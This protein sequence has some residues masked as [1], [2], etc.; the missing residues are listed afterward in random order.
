MT[1]PVVRLKP[2]KG[3]ASRIYKLCLEKDRKTALQGLELAAAMGEPLEGLL[4]EVSVDAEGQL[5]RGKRFTGNDK[6]QP[7]LD[8][9]LLQQLGLAAK[10][11][12]EA[13]LRD[14]VTTLVCKVAVLPD[15]SR[16]AALTSANITLSADFK[17]AD[18]AALGTLAKLRS[19][20]LGSGL[21]MYGQERPT[22]ETL[23]GLDAPRLEVLDASYMDLADIG[24]LSASPRLRQVKLRSN[25]RLESID[26]LEASAG[27][28]E[29]LDLAYC[30]ALRSLRALRGATKLRA[31]DIGGLERIADLS[32]LKKLTRLEAL[33][34]SG[35]EALA[36]IEGLPMKQLATELTAPG[37]AHTSFLA[38]NDMKALSSLRGLPP[39]APGI[40]ELTINRCTVLADLAGIEAGAAVLQELRMDQIAITDL[41]ALA[42]LAHLRKLEIKKCP[43]LV[44]ASALGRLEH[45]TSVRITG[46][47]KLETLP[48]VWKSPVKVLGLTG[49]GALKPL[50]ALPPGIDTKTIEID[51]RKLLPR[52]KPTKALRSD[53]GAVWKLLSSRDV[54]NILM[55]LELSA[56]LGDDFDTLVEGVSVKNGALVR[57]KRFTGTGPAQP[58]LDLALFGLMCR[59]RP[60]SPLAKLRAQITELELVFCQQAP[61]LQ[62]FD[63]LTHLSIHIGD[64]IT[65][66]LAGF[67][68]MPKLQVLKIAGRRWNGK[69]RLVSLQGLQAPA[70]TECNLACSGVEDLSALAQSPRITHLD[71]SENEALS[72]L[73]ALAACAQHLTVLNLRECKQVTT[74]EVLNAA[75]RLKTLDLRECAGL[76]SLQPLAACTALETLDLEMCASLTSLE[77]LA[78]LPIAA[79][80]LYDGTQDFSL[81]GCQA[82]ASLAHLPA[83]GGALTSL[84]LNHTR[85][86][87]D[88]RGLREIP[89]LTQLTARNSGL[90]DL[91]HIGALPAL[92]QVDLQ[93]CA[94][95]KDASPLG[96]LKQLE[97]VDL[98]DSAVTTL[99]RGW[100]GPVTTL[101]L[102]NCP[103]LTS[104]GQLP[105]S[106]VRLVCD[107]SANLARLD[108]MQACRQLEVISVEA[109][110]VLADLGSP[111]AT[112]REIDA[113]RCAS[114]TSLR[115]LQGCPQLQVV[116]IPLS[117]VDASDLRGL[118]SVTIR[119]DL[120]EL[121]KGK[122]KGELR[123]LP[124]ALIDAINALPSVRLEP[125]GPSGSWYGERTIDLTV[126]QNFK[127]LESLG[128]A[129]FDFSCKIEEM[130][131]L[132]ALQGLKSVVFAARGNMSHIL[133]GGVHDSPKKVKTLQLRICKEAQIPPP[134]HLAD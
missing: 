46:C 41:D 5:V 9:L 94:A 125:K 24:G 44:D 134:A 33:D 6:T 11:T 8:A 97:T 51:D 85:N 116:G 108:G 49:C 61:T 99:P 19:L 74:L 123:V 21:L 59:A 3:E 98:A 62:G 75:T 96:I 73:S 124:A 82:L 43:E 92:K 104:L 57:G 121:P 42:S 60:Q 105:A 30:A 58:Y 84:S 93:D 112:L 28:L 128:F 68:P 133:D 95:L 25:Q 18:V 90:S 12:P 77:G 107:G 103:G 35:C 119:M 89:T 100:D 130:T 34:F 36:S 67:G 110:P 13:K 4:T 101:T 20:T 53:V 113:R 81:D 7:F 87:K 52:A 109:C 131:W 72:D 80:K 106:L 71:L 55:G 117:V 29:E 63:E 37:E 78:N 50:K 45:L 69:G 120:N 32:D 26:S 10:G 118:A 47:P 83:F 14:A 91:G 38:L 129:D 70:L 79:N 111:P 40:T 64:D 48:E 56:A 126:F 76:G 66:D 22:L 39:L 16:F 15:L 88:L 65:P 17:G 31:L 23:R 102:K 127:T 115:G 86:L 54:P 114:L 122:T 132:V 1:E 2:L 27:T